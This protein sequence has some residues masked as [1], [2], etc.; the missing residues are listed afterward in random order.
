MILL[1]LSCLVDHNVKKLTKI[2]LPV[3]LGIMPLLLLG[4]LLTPKAAAVPPTAPL[5]EPSSPISHPISNTHTA[6]ATTTVSITYDEP[7]SP[8]TVTSRTFAV[9]AMQTGLVTAA[10]GVNDNTI[11]VTPTHAFHPGEL[12]QASATTRT[13]SLSGQGPISPTVWQFWVAVAGGGGVFIDGQDLSG[14]DSTRD[15]ALG[16]LNGDGGLD[17]FIANDGPNEVWLNDG[18]GTFTDSGQSLG[19]ANSQAVALGDLDGD[20]DLDAFV[21]NKGANNQVWL[22]DGTGTFTGSLSSLCITNSQAVALGDLDGDGDLDAFIGNHDP[23][24]VIWLNDGTGNFASGQ[25]MRCYNSA[26]V[27]L[28]DLDG[29]G[30]LDVFVTTSDKNVDK[31]WLNNGDGS[32]T[33]GQIL[34]ESN[35]RAVALGDVDSDGDLDA[36]I[37]DLGGANKVWL[38]NGDGI[39]T[40]SGQNLGNSETTDAALGDMDGDGDLDAFVANEYIDS[41]TI[42]L[43]DGA[44]ILT[45]TQSLGNSN[46]Q[47]VVLGDIDGDGD[48]DALDGNCTQP[49]EVWLNVPPEVRINQI[50]PNPSYFGEIVEFNGSGTTITITEMLEEYEWTL[51]PVTETCGTQPDPLVLG[52]SAR[53]MLNST[54]VGTHT[55]CL[56]A[57]HSHSIWS[58]YVTTTMTVFPDRWAHSDIAVSREGISFWVDENATIPESNP[59]IGDT[60]Y[61]EV[62]VDNISLYGI[63]DTVTVFVYDGDVV[64]GT[65]VASDTIGPIAAG[66]AEYAIVSWT[67]GS[68]VY[69]APIPDYD[70]GY[71]ILSVDIEYTENVPYFANDPLPPWNEPHIESTYDN[72]R[73]TAFIVA[74]PPIT[75][76]YAISV[77]A[78]IAPAGDE[79]KLYAGYD[80]NL[81]GDAH[82]NWGSQIPVMG[83][84]TTIGISGP[85]GYSDVYNTWTTAPFGRYIYPFQLPP[86]PG[87]YAATVTVFDNNL[88]GATVITFTVEPPP[89]PLPDLYADSFSVILSGD[90]VY[91]RYWRTYTPRRNYDHYG[92]FGVLNE[93]I[94]ISAKVLNGGNKSVT[95]T[96]AVSFYDGSPGG[97]GT[98]IGSTP[99]NELGAGG[100]T[101]VTHAWIPTQTGLHAV[102][103]VVD[104]TDVITESNEINN[105]DAHYYKY[106]Y[107]HNRWFPRDIIDIREKNPDLRATGLL[108]VE[109]NHGRVVTMTATIKNI[110]H[111]KIGY[112]DGFTVIISDGYPGIS[113]T[114]MLKETRING[115]MNQ[116]DDRTINDIIWDTEREGVVPG[117]HHICVAVDTGKE[118]DEELEENNVNCWDPYVFPNEDDLYPVKLTYSNDAPLPTTTITIT[119]TIENRG[120]A[121]FTDTAD[122][123]FYQGAPSDG[124][125]IGTSTLEGPIAGRRGTGTTSIT[126]TTPGSHGSVYI[127]VEY[128]K[129]TGYNAGS[130]TCVRRLTI[131]LNPPPDLRIRS[132]DI[133]VS[134]P[135]PVYGELVGIE[136]DIANIGDTMATNFIVRFYT[137]GPNQ[138]LDQLGSARIVSSLAP[139]MT[140]TVQANATFPAIEPYYAVKVE[141]I[142]SV[143]QGDG[144]LSNNEAT[145]S[146][147]VS[148]LHD[149]TIFKD[150]SWQWLSPTY[151][152]LV[153]VLTV[154]NTGAMTATNPF[155]VTDIMPSSLDYEKIYSF[156][157]SW[158]CL[159]QG[160]TVTCAYADSLAP[161][162]NTKLHIKGISRE[163]TP[164][165]TITNCATV[166]TPSEDNPANNKDCHVIGLG[167]IAGTVTG[168]GGLPLADADVDIVAYRSNDSR[169]DY[170]G[171]TPADA[172]G[173]YTLTLLAAG[174]YKVEFWDW[175]NSYY[176]EF[177]DGVKDFEDATPVGVITG[178]TT[179]ID[180]DLDPIIT[181][182]ITG[183]IVTTDGTGLEGIYAIAYPLDV[184]EQ[185]YGRSG[186]GW[187]SSWL[188]WAKGHR[189]IGATT[190]DVMGTFALTLPVGPYRLYFF[191][192]SG[193]WRSQ[194]Y[195]GVYSLAKAT[196]ITVTEDMTAVG[197][198]KA[199]QAQSDAGT[200]VTLYQSEPPRSQLGVP[201]YTG[202]NLGD[203]TY[204]VEIPSTE[205][206]NVTLAI[207]TTMLEPCDASQTLTAELVLI[208]ADDS[209]TLAGPYPMSPTGESGEYTGLIPGADLVD[210]SEVN[211][212]RYCNGTQDG[213]SILVAA[214]LVYTPTGRITDAATGEPIPD[215]TV[216]LYKVPGWLPDDPWVHSNLCE[217]GVIASPALKEFDPPINPQ[218][219]NEAGYYSWDLAEGCWC[220]GAEGWG[221]ERKV[222]SVVCVPPEVTDLDLAL[223][224]YR[225]YLPVILKA[226]NN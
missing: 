18:A 95:D 225:I 104:E 181:G 167:E 196:V 126:W 179:V 48:L 107:W 128:V 129:D 80:A 87:T 212:R 176:S 133:H 14:N 31:V 144:D 116:K 113:D 120:A 63:T 21:A 198:T 70:D 122:I 109:P 165:D 4:F 12:V 86:T 73:A 19:N 5:L 175:S 189:E 139:G 173:H 117:Q 216:T 6:P 177:Y 34:P 127:Y 25:T 209:S 89:E 112:G 202:I 146:F 182:A 149:L 206:N 15:L 121:E 37:G 140:T 68:D 57:R 218:I 96:F 186:W 82:Y 91:R 136:A 20:G 40:D 201:T 45:T 226:S 59:S 7:I 76:T 125:V 118:I 219:T 51:V 55:V 88:L 74:G 211:I 152:E 138:G 3:F 58:S 64:S 101:I 168:P 207:T 65:L 124:N 142:P 191:D 151:A 52:R 100:E 1:C 110:G 150:I 174:A 94:T 33:S 131:V 24:D 49:N 42:W 204:G 54:P 223:M 195:D 137:D 29:D 143:E 147:D 83:A 8:T 164:T 62:R 84:E 135:S 71:K 50:I 11:I 72:N 169:W 158:N 221:P 85:G 183:S 47:G 105:Y 78:D 32:F 187:S 16:D 154:T 184:N 210:G 205:Q 162:A 114:I 81:F 160:L 61:I 22:N 46:S 178:T 171:W 60:V 193:E 157:S 28:G 215:A 97:G 222:S 103:V 69:G 197:F 30:D 23:D 123:T 170:A 53:L 115:P 98:L 119:A 39:F 161:N 180:A 26:D 38:N 17:V 106:Q 200:S 92:L 36:F 224:P 217:L 90:G 43:N 13:L 35:G 77:T 99:V 75:G 188:A 148:L 194:Y 44:G 2:I 108:Y 130:R 10:H 111:D 141:V 163:I 208:D 66:I 27:A 41:N 220:V 156:P 155:T 166:D 134:P 199:K 213:D 192:Q 132:E 159:P 93:P 203:G 56:R 214:I 190:T 172:T 67:V 9:H 102:Q 185:D 153:Y 145:T 79:P